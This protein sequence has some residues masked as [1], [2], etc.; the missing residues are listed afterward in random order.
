MTETCYQVQLGGG[1]SNVSHP[2]CNITCTH[3]ALHQ[4]LSLPL[5]QNF[6]LL[7]ENLVHCDT[8]RVHTWIVSSIDAATE[9]GLSFAIVVAKSIRPLIS[10]RKAR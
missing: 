6:H 8:H 9:T 3:I 5:A 10:V 1:G 7:G 4:A 2:A